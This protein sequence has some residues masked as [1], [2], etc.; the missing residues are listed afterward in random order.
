MAKYE[1]NI[2][3]DFG[4]VLQSIETGILR[5]SLSASLED[6]SDFIQNDVRLAVRVFER[7]SMLGK[8]R[9]SLNVVLVGEGDRLFLSAITSGGSQAVFFKINTFGEEAFLDQIVAIVKKYQRT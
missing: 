9:V 7:Y 1:T 6:G 3:G 4:V 5:G 8:N 2:V